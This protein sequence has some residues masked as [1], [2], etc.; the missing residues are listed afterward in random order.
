MGGCADSD[1]EIIH[2]EEASS[3]AKVLSRNRA[4]ASA[5][6]RDYNQTYIKSLYRSYGVGYGYCAFGGY[7]DYESVRDVIINLDSLQYYEE[8]DRCLCLID[9]RSPR[10]Y[11]RVMTGEDSEK[12]MKS[13]SANAGLSSDLKFFQAEVKGSYAS[14]DLRSNYYSF[15]TIHTG[16]VLGS[17]H[18]DPLSLTELCRRH[19][20]IIAPGLRQ[21]ISEIEDAMTG[22]TP[23]LQ[24]ANELVDM[25]YS[26]YGTHLLYHADL[27]GRLTFL[28]TFERASLDSRSGLSA[29][30]EAKLM[31]VFNYK[32]SA[33]EEYSIQQTSTRSKNRFTAIGGDVT[34]ISQMLYVDNATDPQNTIGAGVV[35]QW[36]KSVR[37]N[38]DSIYESNAELVEIK[39]YPLEAFVSA[40]GYEQVSALLKHR[41][42]SQQ[43]YEDG[44]FPRVYD[45][46]C[47][48]FPTDFLWQVSN[49]QINTIS[50][51]NEVIGELDYECI[52]GREFIT[53]Y[54]TIDGTLCH[55]GIARGYGSDSLYIITWHDTIPY[56]TSL[57]LADDATDL[58]YRGGDIDIVPDSDQNYDAS[59]MLQ[60]LTTC[61]WTSNA[62]AALKVGPYTMI[63]GAY[64]SLGDKSYS[65]YATVIND[66]PIGC[67]EVTYQ[68]MQT[69]LRIIR[70]NYNRCPDMLRGK[71]WLLRKNDEVRPSSAY[72]ISDDMDL[73]PIDNARFG[74]V[75]C[76][77]TDE[78][79]YP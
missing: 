48:S 5:Y 62:S 24:L 19:P 70:Q 20:S 50:C 73:I 28:S 47:A 6:T 56:I 67:R 40:L 69:I 79:R 66:I 71:Q 43:E 22:M 9:D 55:E 7:A 51:S 4:L 34:L 75:L 72:I 57:C 52:K 77:R 45:R 41:I 23:N 49:T 54:P 21:I 1:M 31:G 12:L 11:Q 2:S 15:C 8:S 13:L 46:V 61:M 25:M 37:L 38:Y 18:L 39:I 78:F 65:N 64:A 26:I 74:F 30:A 35:E 76:R 3:V 10:A 63:Q 68:D 17:R 53:Y 14:S 16:M 59:C 33:Q 36:Y 58:Y 42:G 29:S 44:M 27:G 60:L 32:T